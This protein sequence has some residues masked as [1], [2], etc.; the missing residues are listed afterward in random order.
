MTMV[1]WNSDT[2]MARKFGNQNAG[3]D[4]F[5]MT[6]LKYSTDTIGKYEVSTITILLPTTV[7]NC[8][9]SG[10]SWSTV[11]IKPLLGNTKVQRER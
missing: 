6:T 2:K 4:L 9:T 11:C 1:C 8:T 5:S 10:L 3:L 7:L